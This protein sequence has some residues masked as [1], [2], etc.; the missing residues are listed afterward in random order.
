M[1]L[2]VPLSVIKR[3]V[4]CAIMGMVKEDSSRS[5]LKMDYLLILTSG[6]VQDFHLKVKYGHT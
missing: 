1:D 2:L 4:N 3:E 5:H 6:R